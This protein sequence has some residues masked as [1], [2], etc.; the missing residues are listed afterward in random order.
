MGHQ[1]HRVSSRPYNTNQDTIEIM[2]KAVSEGVF[3]TKNKLCLSLE[4]F[5]GCGGFATTIAAAIAAV[6]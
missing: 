2:E 5:Y 1:L 6:A 4:T 3:P